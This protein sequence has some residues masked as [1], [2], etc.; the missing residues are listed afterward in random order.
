MSKFSHHTLFILFIL[1]YNIGYGQATRKFTGK[2]VS[3]DGNNKTINNISVRLVNQQSGVTGTD[4][5]FVIAINNDVEEVTLELAN[6]ELTIIYPA[7][8]RVNIPKNPNAVV[9]FV[10]GDSPKEILTKAVAKSNNEIKNRLSQLGVKQDGI[11]ETLNVFIAEIQKMSDIKR[12]DLT[13]QIDLAS[14]RE[15]FYP[16]LASSINGYINEAKDLKDAFKFTARHAFNDPMALQILVDAI[17]SYNI[18]FEDLNKNSAG[19]EMKVSDYWQSEAKA[20][21]VREL[22]NYALGEI[23][24]ANVFILNLKISEINELNGSN[25]KGSKKEALQEN[26]L[27]DIQ[28]SQLQ[29]ERRLEDLDKRA[30]IVLSKLAT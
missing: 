13:S 28:T 8:G 26:I 3:F 11:E 18:V 15:E 23:H 6:S 2:L 20:N 24:S 5:I 27:R 12:A 9:E 10:V 29:L 16:A 7:G 30:Q 14:K 17:S 19:F 22:F 25:L 1:F 21:E 4:G